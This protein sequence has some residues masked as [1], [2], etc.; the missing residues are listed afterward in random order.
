VDAEIYNGVGG[1]PGLAA[2]SREVPGQGNLNKASWRRTSRTRGA[3]DAECS[4]IEQRPALRAP[5]RRVPGSSAGG[6]YRRRTGPS[7]YEA[8]VSRRQ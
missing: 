2:T 4:A 6:G 1:S 3:G 8:D 5:N 7:A